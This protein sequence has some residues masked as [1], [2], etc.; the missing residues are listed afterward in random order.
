MHHQSQRFA[1]C[2]FMHAAQQGWHSKLFIY[3]P[4]N[5]NNHLSF[6]TLTRAV[7]L[8]LTVYKLK[9][10]DLLHAG[11]PSPELHQL[12]LLSNPF[13]LQCNYHLSNDL[14]S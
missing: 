3:T 12:V 5:I 6:A 13:I 4:K 10:N 7:T 14:L 8:R 1:L 9:S 11:H 2:T